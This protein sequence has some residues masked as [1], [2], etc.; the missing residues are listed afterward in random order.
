MSR[1]SLKKTREVTVGVTGSGRDSV[2]CR[3]VRIM[4][5]DSGFS[6]SCVGRLRATNVGCCQSPFAGD[7][8]KVMF[9]PVELVT[10]VGGIYPVTV[11][12]RARVPSLD[13]C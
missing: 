13:L 10:L 2:G 11:R 12:A 5:K 1:F 9:F 3:V 4:E 7:G 8:V 6:E